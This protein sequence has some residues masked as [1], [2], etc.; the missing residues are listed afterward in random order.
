MAL[1]IPVSN[2]SPDERRRH[3]QNESDSIDTDLTTS[4]VLTTRTKTPKSLMDMPPEIRKI[5]Y[6]LVIGDKEIDCCACQIA[7]WKKYWKYIDSNRDSR[8]RPAWEEIPFIINPRIN[9]MLV[10]KWMCE[11]VKSLAEQSVVA[12]FHSI[13]CV[14]TRLEASTPTFLRAWSQVRVCRMADFPAEHSD[15]ITAWMDRMHKRDLEKFEEILS[16]L[17]SVSPQREPCKQF[18]DTEVDVATPDSQQPNGWRYEIRKEVWV[19][20]ETVFDLKPLA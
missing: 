13:K 14:R 11:D 1:T 10:N 4:Q 15:Q 12:K 5:V 2:D 3:Q 9:L 16:P 18:A 7:A 19:G 17:Y 8:Q 20:L 6:D